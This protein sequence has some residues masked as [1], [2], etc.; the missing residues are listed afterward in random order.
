MT[1]RHMI[2]SSS[3][4]YRKYYSR[5]EVVEA[6]AAAVFVAELDETER[7]AVELDRAVL[8]YASQTRRVASLAERIS[9]PDQLQSVQ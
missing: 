6:E 1:L 7:F 3:R 4:S 5:D 2:D 9:R 8:E